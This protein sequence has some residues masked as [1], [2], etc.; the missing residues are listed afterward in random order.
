MVDVSSV[1]V[2]RSTGE[3]YTIIVACG[4]GGVASGAQS[5]TEVE[6]SCTGSADSLGAEGK[7][8]VYFQAL[9][10][11]FK[12]VVAGW[13]GRAHEAWPLYLVAALVATNIDCISSSGALQ[14][15]LEKG[16]ICVA[17]KA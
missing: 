16:V 9:S 14:T 5:M 1:E 6:G 10:S 2:A 17:G 12:D 3:A 13:T 8:A 4:T 15:V 7:A 11:L